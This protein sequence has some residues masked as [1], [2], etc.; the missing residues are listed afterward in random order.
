MGTG[1]PQGRYIFQVLVAITGW[2]GCPLVFRLQWEGETLISAL[3]F[4]H[5]SW[6]LVV[7]RQ[8]RQRAWGHFRARVL[9]VFLPGMSGGPDRGSAWVH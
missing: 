4:R 9:P 2:E 6:S 3:G 1:G 5:Y 8:G 7:V